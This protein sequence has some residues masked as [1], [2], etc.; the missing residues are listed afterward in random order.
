MRKLF[1][2]IACLVLAV[3]V[4]SCG[5]GDGGVGPP[6][7]PPPPPPPCPANTFCM[8]VSTFSPKTLTVPVN[9]TVSWTNNDEGV[10]HNVT[11][12]TAA[13]RNA[14]G[15][16]DGTGNITDFNTGTRT[17]QFATPGT[18]SFQCTLHLGMTG[19]LTVTP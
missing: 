4:L 5:G 11:W 3:G 16:G 12:D 2:P 6:P 17:R 13:G 10:F 8:V 9:T 14:A 18:F 15:A 1:G 19:T 7:P